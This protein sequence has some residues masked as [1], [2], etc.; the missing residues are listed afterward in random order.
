MNTDEEKQ[1]S[2]KGAKARKGR[3]KPMHLNS[4]A[5]LGALGASILIRV[6]RCPIGG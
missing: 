6:H 5:R 3:E 2:A 4:F 1:S